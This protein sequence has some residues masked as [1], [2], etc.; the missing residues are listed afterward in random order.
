MTDILRFSI[1][2]MFYVLGI[3]SAFFLLIQGSRFL[4]YLHNF[5]SRTAFSSQW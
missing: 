5:L 4:Y 2:G 1:K 3:L